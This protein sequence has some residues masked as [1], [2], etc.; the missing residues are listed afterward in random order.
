[1]FERFT[2][3]ARHVVVLSQEEARGLHHNY[4]GTEHILLGLLG[5]REGIA[6]RVLE[7]FGLTAE[8]VR[9]EVVAIVGEG[10]QDPQTGHI[11][12]TPR[13]KK[14]LE[15]SLR[16]ALQLHHNYIGTEHILLGVIR[17]GDGVAAQILRKHGDL[18]AVRAAVLDQV[19]AGTATDTGPMRR[20]L[21]GRRP[22][23]GELGTPGP[24]AGVTEATPDDP[25]LSAS[26][27]ADVTLTEASLLAGDSPVGSHHLLL[28]ALV[29]PNSAA[30]KALTAIGVDLN[31]AKDAL[32]DVAIE[33]TSDELPEDAGR[34]QMNIQVSEETVTFLATDPA[35]AKAASDA[36][37]AVGPVSGTEGGTEGGLP[38]G[39]IR[40]ADLQGA[41]AAGLAAAWKSLHDAL[42]TITRTAT[43]PRK[44]APE[45]G[46]P[47]SAD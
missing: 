8:G 40:G 32:R 16:E 42:E 9:Q 26:P 46:N 4:I 21:R 18:L 41:A 43:T 12:F 17:E 10:K 1:M 33:G 25:G 7:S 28:A 14:V 5:E 13:A 19:P 34:R 45:K 23:P 15:L 3:I 30:A 20:W 2:A 36:L 11:P 22:R 35:I 47:E 38:G 24:G 27:A 44:D 6:F 29:D 37:K 31:Q 39:V